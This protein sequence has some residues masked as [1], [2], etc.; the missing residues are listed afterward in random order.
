[1]TQLAYVGGIPLMR[2][3]QNGCEQGWKLASRGIQTTRLVLSG[4]LWPPVWLPTSRGKYQS[5][6][7][8]KREEA[9]A[10]MGALAYRL[11]SRSTPRQLSTC[12]SV[13]GRDRPALSCLTSL[14]GAR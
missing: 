7:Q 13:E 4:P 14:G 8:S 2:L 9:H 3:R 12:F 10:P 1:L 11:C 6:Q 5:A